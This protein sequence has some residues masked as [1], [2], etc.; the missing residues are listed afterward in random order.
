VVL[1]HARL[2][3]SSSF[4]GRE[5]AQ[6]ITRPDKV[7]V[8]WPVEVERWRA[9]AAEHGLG[10]RELTEVCAHPRAP[11]TPDAHTVRANLLGP[12]GLT[13]KTQPS[14]TPTS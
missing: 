6:V 10:A 7:R 2:N 4:E 8:D 9:R 5:R 14:R 1:E 13:A 3:G 12:A 11:R